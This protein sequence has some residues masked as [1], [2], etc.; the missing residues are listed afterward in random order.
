MTLCL[1]HRGYRPVPE[2]PRRLRIFSQNFF[3]FTWSPALR[4]MLGCGSGIRRRECR[5][6][7]LVAV[8]RRGK[9]AIRDR[10]RPHADAVELKRGVPLPGGVVATADRAGP[11][12]TIRR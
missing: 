6:V 9:C 10:S 7:E 11:S 4:S 5:W 3:D 2:S 8:L 1:P 12:L